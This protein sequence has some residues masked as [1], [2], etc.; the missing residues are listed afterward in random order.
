MTAVVSPERRGLAQEMVGFETMSTHHGKGIKR[1]KREIECPVTPQD[2]AA[3]AEHFRR[4]SDMLDQ[5]ATINKI[6][7][8]G[9]ERK[10]FHHVEGEEGY[11]LFLKERVAGDFVGQER[12][13]PAVQDRWVA[14]SPRSQ[15]Q[16][17]AVP[18]VD[19]PSFQFVD[20][21]RR[22]LRLHRAIIV[23][24]TEPVPGKFQDWKHCSLS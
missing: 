14:T 6:E 20:G 22:D 18:Y 7:G 2:T 5:T 12:L 9:G 23:I 17:V 1:R 15:F 11:A 24:G 8:F 21:Y 19:A 3:L 10:G 4:V 16:Y 13:C